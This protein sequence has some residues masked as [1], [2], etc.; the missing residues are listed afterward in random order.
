MQ[1][2]IFT[3]A[4]SSATALSTAATAAAAAQFG[5]RTLLASVGP[6][7]GLIALQPGP[8][9]QT[10]APNLDAWALDALGDLAAF[11]NAV[12]R[13]GGNGATAASAIA[14]DELPIIPGSDL[15][16]AVARLRSLGAGYD[17]VCV[18]AGAHAALLRALAVPDTFRWSLRLLFGLDRGPGR[19]SASVSRAIVPGSLLPFEWLGQVQQ[20]RADLE[21]LRDAT[22]D[23]TSTRVRYVLRPDTAGL[24]DARVA[25]PAL[26]LFGLAVETLL[27][28]PLL[29]ADQVNGALAALSAEQSRIIAETTATWPDHQLLSFPLGPTPLTAAELAA[30]GATIYAN[31]SPLPA[32]TVCPPIVVGAAPDPSIAIRLPGLRREDLGLTLSGDELIV[33][34]GPYRR[35]LLMPEDLR[36]AGAIKAAR[37][38]DTLIVRPRTE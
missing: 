37:Q 7:H 9:P 27:A 3:G 33:R 13:Q 14:G 5:A 36:S 22:L 2:L 12:R 34:A 30:L 35:H 6:A 19:S 18:D 32:T 8:E 25:V 15:F 17:L 20:A 38:G 31:T 11:W 29:P 28:G 10:L 21:Q 16:L 24:H 23:P 1:M 4:D 26:H